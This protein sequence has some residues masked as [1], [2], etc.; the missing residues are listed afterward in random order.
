MLMQCG[1][2]AI[3]G[4]A[5]RDDSEPQAVVRCSGEIPEG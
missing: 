3:V 2:I 5:E 1:G 4:E